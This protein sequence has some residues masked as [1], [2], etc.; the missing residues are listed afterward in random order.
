MATPVIQIV[1]YSDLHIVGPDYLTQRL[2]FDALLKRL[3]TTLK[4]GVAGASMAA[5]QAFEDFLRE[6]AS[7]AA[8]RDKP[9]WLV[10]T[11]DGTTFG[12]DASLDAWLNKWS[13]AFLAAAGANAKQMVLYGNHD[14]WPGTFPLLAPRSM[15]NHRNTL[16]SARFPQTWPAQPLTTPLQSPGGPEVQL[17]TL[18]SVDHTLLAN[19]KALGKVLP[20]RHWQPIGGMPG[21]RASDDLD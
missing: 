17:Y 12:D 7:D 20:D 10:D 2:C 9:T 1:H 6:I 21:P 13:P 19:T 18:N 11:G 16:R 15:D 3:P 8:W 5:L 4:Q 14:A